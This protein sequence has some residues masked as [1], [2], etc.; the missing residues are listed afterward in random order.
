[1]PYEKYITRDEVIDFYDID[2]ESE[3]K[4]VHMKVGQFTVNSYLRE[5]GYNPDDYDGSY[6]MLFLAALFWIG[7][8]LSNLGIVTWSVGQ[9]EEERFGILSR[10]FQRWQPMFFFARGMAKD[11]Y[12]LLPHETYRM[13][14]NR[15]MEQFNLSYDKDVLYS[16]PQIYKDTSHRG[17]GWTYETEDDLDNEVADIDDMD[18]T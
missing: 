15:C 18:L 13:A 7:E 2:I 4:E 9:I 17:Y 12:G 10:R 16:G 1:M 14:A 5:T 8:I 6:E 11:F 3:V